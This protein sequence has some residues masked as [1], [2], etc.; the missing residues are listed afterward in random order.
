MKK[1]LTLA[2]SLLM[3]SSC[4]VFSVSAENV[5]LAKNSVYAYADDVAG[6]FKSGNEDDACTLLTDGVVAE[7]ESPFETV[8][9]QG[10]SR[11]VTVIFDLGGLY[12]D[13]K[14]VNFLA[15]WDSNTDVAG[16]RGFSGEKTQIWFSE[17]GLNFSRNKDF[18]M[19]RDKRDPESAES[20]Y[21]YKFKFNSDVKAKAVKIVMYSPA[22]ILSL[23]EIE[24]IGGG[25]APEAPVVSEEP[26]SEEIIEESSVEA[27]SEAVS[28]VV[29]EV[30]SE[31]TSEVASEATSEAVSEAVS[32]EASS[33]AASNDEGGISPVIIVVIAVVVVAAIVGV[34][35]F[36]KKK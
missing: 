29:S 21:D 20:Y 30:V 26:S 28:E 10:T 15:V 19:S 9:V 23:S 35:I 4:F 13:I 11:I 33:E 1:I 8:C 18:K 25:A 12:S 2:L 7:M 22:Y 3:I 32:A 5:N 24:I 36:T 27:P 34:V 16:N 14:S 31:E 17:D 6:A